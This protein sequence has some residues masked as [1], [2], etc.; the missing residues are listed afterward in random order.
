MEESKEEKPDKVVENWRNPDGTLKPG[1]PVLENWHRPKGKTLKEYQAQKY[2]DMTDEQKEEYLKDINKITCWKM[3]EGNPHQ[4]IK[5][6]EELGIF[7]GNLTIE[8]KL[9]R[10]RQ[11]LKGIGKDGGTGES[12]IPAGGDIEI[13]EDGADTQGSGEISETGESNQEGNNTFATEP[14]QDNGSNDRVDDTAVNQ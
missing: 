12:D 9:Q 4:G 14:S 8:E 13:S 3:G 1:H 2:R 10:I 11:C 5:L 7:Y 6:E